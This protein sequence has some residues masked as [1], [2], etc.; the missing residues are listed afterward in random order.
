MLLR[1]AVMLIAF[2]NPA[3]LHAQS[4]LPPASFAAPACEAAA[5]AADSDAD[6]VTD[7]CELSLA[8]GWAPWLL[9]DPA[10]CAWTGGSSERRLAGGYFFAAEALSVDGG[11]IRIA[12]LPA[13]F[14]DCGWRGIQRVLRLGRA[15]AHAGDSEL[16]I[17]DVV[18]GADAS[19]RPSAVFLSAHCGGRSGGRCRWFQGS[20]LGGFHWRGRSNE[21]RPDVWVARDKHANYPSRRA[22]ESGHWLQETC[23]SQ[24]VAYRFPIRSHA[25]NIGSRR[26][27]AFGGM[28]CVD[29]GALPI[30]AAGVLPESSECFWDSRRRFTG[31]QGAG[32][33]SADAYAEILE[34]F[35]RM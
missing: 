19:W 35:A 10:D 28:G 30:P 26:V 9:A 3:R 21:V 5:K 13:Y 33:G 20:G 8:R 29:G 15:N 22:C 23:A 34:R 4:P 18:R 24:P 14:R 1:H 11:A 31:W 12:Y 17:I 6:G 27:P 2:Q 16:I 32:E 25:Q 7:A